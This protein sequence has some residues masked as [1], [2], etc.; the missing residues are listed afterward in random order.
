MRMKQLSQYGDYAIAL[1]I[2]NGSVGWVALTPDYRLV[3]AKGRELI[4]VRLFD[5]ANT[6]ENR[7]MFRTARRRYSRRRWRLGFL[8]AMFDASLAQVD[9]GF[10][11]RRKYS[12][13]HPE[14]K[15]N[16]EHWG[17]GVLFDGREQ[18]IQFYR[19][20]PTI[21]HLR[22][23]LMEDDA[24][25]DIREVYLAIH[26]I[27]KYRGN[28]LREGQLDAT[29]LFDA[30][31]LCELIGKIVNLGNADTE[32]NQE[33][34]ADA[35]GL[36]DALTSTKGSKSS[37]VDE[38]LEIIEVNSELAAEARK[39]V[40]AILKGLEGNKL[41]LATIFSKKDLE[42]EQKK[43]LSLDFTSANY[44]AD[45]AEVINSGLLEEEEIALLAQLQR[46]YSAIALKQLL[47]DSISLS[48][49]MCAKYEKHRKN[50]SIIKKHLRDKDNA[51]DVNTNY[52]YLAGWIYDSEG[53][54][55]PRSSGDNRMKADKY[56]KHLI[57]DSSLE[58][59]I[60]QSLLHDIEEGQLFPV[61]RS[62]DNGVIPYQLH[63]NEL[64]RIIAKQSKYYPF[65][66][67]TFEKEGRQVNKIE[68]LLTFRVPYYVGP[69]VSREQCEH[70]GDNAENH[71]MKRSE[72]GVITPWNF[73]EKVNKDES[74]R[75][76]ID[77]LVS[78]DIYLLGEA[79]L[80]KKSLLYQ[81]YEV[82]NELNNVRLSVRT[83]RH[84]QDKNRMRLGLNEKELI[85][86][87]LFK[88][89]M[90][91]SKKKVEEL[92]KKTY[93]RDYE[94]F[95]LADNNKFLSS[96]SS[97]NRMCKVFGDRQFVDSHMD[98]MEKII[99]LQ[100]VF[101]D[102]K[103]LR[104][105]LEMLDGLTA[106]QCD[107]LSQTHYTGWGKFSRKLLTEKKG[108]C[109]IG[110]DF[111]PQAH[112]IIEVLRE[113][114]RNFM[115]I[116]RDEIYGFDKWIEEYNSGENNSQTLMEVIDSLRISPKVK[117]GIVQSIRVIDDISKA[118]GSKP[119]RIFLEM[120]DDVEARERTTSR[121][122]RLKNLYK[123][124]KLG[125]EFKE[126]YESL[127]GQTDSALQDDRLFLY[128][129]QLGKDMYSGEELNIAELS[130]LYDIDHIIPQAVTQNDSLDNRVLVKRAANARKSDS[131]QYLPELVDKRKD[132]W[133]QLLD[134]QLISRVKYERLV[135]QDDFHAKE[136]ER[137]VARSLVETRQIMKN[138]ATIMRNQYG[139]SAAVIGLS[140]SQTKEM[141]RY[142][143]FAQKNRDINDYHHA[144]DALC[145]GAVGQFVVNKGF[146]EDGIVSGDAL[147]SYNRYLQDYLRSYRERLA[148][149]GMKRGNPFGF[150]VG[151]MC[152]QN[153]D[154]HVDPKTGAIVW[155]E[156][157]AD[158][159][160]KVMNYRK[161]IVTQKVGDE[162]GPLYDETRYGKGD[163]KGAK[164]IPF[165]KHKKNA[166]LYGGFSSEKNAYSVLIEAKKKVRLVNIAMRDIAAL[167]NKP[168]DD[169]LREVLSRKKPEYANARILLR[170]VPF[171]QL[172]RYGGALMVIKS[173]M[174]LNNAWQLWLEKRDYDKLDSYLKCDNPSVDDSMY[175][176]DVLVD[177]VDKYYPC[178]R[179]DEQERRDR[180][181]RFLQLEAAEQRQVIKGIVDALHADA[182]TA[183]LTPLGLSE[184]WGRMQKT[185]GYSLADDD[186]FIFQSVSGLFETVKT[187]KQLREEAES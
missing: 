81:E 170:H 50:W 146:F 10:L 102:K 113:T 121:L 187:V 14:D 61:Q 150:I 156:N 9:P 117:R 104:H 165:D 152:S 111:A 155:S 56:F 51:S 44:D 64:K 25:H 133:Q 67:E 144:Q 79:T 134:A 186:A 52:G 119:K 120:A 112:S 39:I 128:Y 95:G 127:N 34:I 8:N 21:Y 47:G 178:H 157:D 13:V 17:A 163:A 169:A 78:T 173:A 182:K 3:R 75:K 73:D 2:G 168:N 158:Y 139:D 24:Q 108:S 57:E 16:A 167:G 110:D 114:D 90:M 28:F 70:N 85:I 84:W 42:S 63:L 88:T 125:R 135:R 103:T 87:K 171:K 72:D 48:E 105:Q 35:R 77:R 5:P 49:S 12:W 138:V 22:K 174:E 179:F 58:N 181:N 96:L 184:R 7:R 31:E 185:A 130:T 46:Q 109:K 26:H 6:A 54:R 60:K 143:G 132:F 37:R 140:S 86:E 32:L 55:K 41:D 124:A 45:S 11:S 106:E 71:W 162:Y 53:Q 1:D 4:G 159:L 15:A 80:P 74:A 183:N 59:D 98:L 38:A 161:I 149:E 94:V 122:T 118:V 76:F 153:E 68:G 176:F 27:V 180:K 166:E 154:M 175:F 82:L 99:E 65:L 141:R 151:S 116:I 89:R 131:F 33:I 62:S 66:A 177:V 107:Q 36:N 160:R 30:D 137:F 142:L 29:N 164:G 93:G 115:E 92:L 40:K 91:V 19:D 147:N 148:Q 145:I 43:A 101:E 18:D 126:I 123:N 100:T 23:A 97:Y 69:L 129:I 83:G 136:K 172:I 20:Y